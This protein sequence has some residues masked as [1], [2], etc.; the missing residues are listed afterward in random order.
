MCVSAPTFVT[1]PSR[2][3]GKSDDNCDDDKIKIGWEYCRL[4]KLCEAMVQNNTIPTMKN[5]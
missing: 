5:G 2:I 4:R 1:K 3:F